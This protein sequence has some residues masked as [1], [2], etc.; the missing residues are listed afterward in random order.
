MPDKKVPADSVKPTNQ[1][2]TPFGALL[3]RVYW[4]VLGHAAIIISAFFIV[5]NKSPRIAHTLYVLLVA[6]L[7]LVRFID[8]K[9][10]HG[11]TSE[12]TVATMAHWRRFSV[13]VIAYSILIWAAALLA[14]RFNFI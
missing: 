7:I 13:I 10:Y 4:M 5:S 11:E 9:I 2:Y 14:A 3:T 1:E 8:I 6:C 12:G